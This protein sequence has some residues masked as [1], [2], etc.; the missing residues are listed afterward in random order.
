MF[1]PQAEFIGAIGRSY[2][3]IIFPSVAGSGSITAF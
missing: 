1:D 3:Q 2:G